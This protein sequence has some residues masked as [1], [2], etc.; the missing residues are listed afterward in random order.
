MILLYYSAAL[1][2]IEVNKLYLFIIFASG[3]DK[4]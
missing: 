1:A 2:A 3:V 4:T